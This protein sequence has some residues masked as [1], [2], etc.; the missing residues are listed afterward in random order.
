MITK[1]KKVPTIKIQVSPPNLALRLELLRKEKEMTREELSRKLG[2]KPGTL[3]VIEREQRGLT[4][5][6]LKKYSQIFGISIESFLFPQDNETD[7][8]K[9]FK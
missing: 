2:I 7:K 3:F 8:Y 5:S 9:Y 4:F 1:L 6:L